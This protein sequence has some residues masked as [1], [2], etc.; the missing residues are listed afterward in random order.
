MVRRKTLGKHYYKN[1]QKN[2]SKKAV[3][4]RSAKKGK[5]LGAGHG[6][7]L[8]RVSSFSRRPKARVEDGPS[9]DPVVPS[10]PILGTSTRPRS[11]VVLS[12]TTSAHRHQ[13]A[14]SVKSRILANSVLI[15]H[16]DEA[17]EHIYIN[18]PKIFDFTQ[19]IDTSD[20][21]PEKKEG[22]YTYTQT[23]TNPF[24]TMYLQNIKPLIESLPTTDNFDEDNVVLIMTDLHNNVNTFKT[25]ITNY[26]E[27]PNTGITMVNKSKL[28]A[29][30]RLLTEM[31]K[32]SHHDQY[33]TQHI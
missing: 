30:V 18:S 15:K 27:S 11:A 28:N 14:T 33:F 7:M 23:T 19:P 4:R 20:L 1:R 8:K 2:Y 29:C 13:H 6:G 26:L 31:A 17:I 21:F 10:G 3:R 24:L 9:A 32:N 12:G 22:S 5:R 16:G 25:T